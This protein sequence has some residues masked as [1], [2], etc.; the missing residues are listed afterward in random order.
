MKFNKRVEETID[1]QKTRLMEWKF[2]Q[3]R[4]L[5]LKENDNKQ[6]LKKIL[7]H[8]NILRTVKKKLCNDILNHH[9]SME[10]AYIDSHFI[11]I[12]MC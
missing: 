4:N 10:Q 9:D 3:K 7:M 12:K 8:K 1:L 11:L 5:I 2:M 6:N